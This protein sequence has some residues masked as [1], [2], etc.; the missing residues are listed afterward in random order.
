MPTMRSCSLQHVTC[1][2]LPVVLILAAVLCQSLE[3]TAQPFFPS[4]RSKSF[5]PG[6]IPLAFL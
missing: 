2:L 5:I 3:S 6:G 1:L 4:P